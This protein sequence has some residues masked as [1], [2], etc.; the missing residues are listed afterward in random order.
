MF[1]NIGVFIIILLAATLG[2]MIGLGGGF[3]IIPSLVLLLNLPIHKAIALSLISI[4]SISLSA[5]ITYSLSEHIDY[6][7]GL[8]LEI[9]S[10]VGAFNGAQI[11]LMLKSEILISLFSIFL[12]YAG[13]RMLMGSKIDI[14]A[15]GYDISTPKL[16]FGGICAFGAGLLSGLL[17]IGGG[18]VNVPIM[19]LILN[20]PMKLAAG[21]SM[22]MISLTT[23]SGSYVYFQAGVIDYYLASIAIVGGFIGAQIGSR[24]GLR[25]K[26]I[27]LRRIFGFIL[28]ILSI[29]M[30][31]KG[32]GVFT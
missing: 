21:T 6:K 29:M 27:I 7:L 28:I 5:V 11:S 19:V 2:S 10:I 3:M 18:S 30:I 32:L 8:L 4:L 17:G 26:G 25:I 14:K 9:M 22:F 16:I 31:M 1:Y 24:L 23:A 15:K 12:F 20:V 13:Y